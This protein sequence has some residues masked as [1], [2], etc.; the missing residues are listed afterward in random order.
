MLSSASVAPSLLLFPLPA[1]L[2]Y[3]LPSLLSDYSYLSSSVGP[4][5]SPGSVPQASTSFTV[6][7]I[8]H[9][10]HYTFS[11]YLPH[12]AV[13]STAGG[14]TPVCFVHCCVP[15]TSTH[16]AWHMVGIQ[17]GRLMLRQ[18]HVFQSMVPEHLLCVRHRTRPWGFGGKPKSTHSPLKEAA[19]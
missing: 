16:S 18:S 11:M 4:S 10:C 2:F 17:L 14:T 9:S 5:R 19:I 12:S 15:S 13:S 6:R 3:T 7:H 1:M 8:P